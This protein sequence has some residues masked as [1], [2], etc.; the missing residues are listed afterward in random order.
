MTGASSSDRRG[1]SSRYVPRADAGEGAA[2]GR[3]NGTRGRTNGLVNG[4][5]RTNGLVNG[6]GKPNGLVNGI[7]YTNGV[8][9]RRS[10]YG[11][12][13]SSDYRRT[14]V[15]IA[16]SIV[17]MLL[18]SVFLG[19]QEPV[20]SPFAVD[21]DFSEWVGVP[22]YDDPVDA[23]PGYADLVAFAI[24]HEPGRLFAYGRTRAPMFPGNETSSVYVLID[25]PASAG[26]AVGGRDVDFLAEAWGWNGRIR[27]AA[28]REWV[29]D[30][31]R[32]NA[33]S[34]RARG[35]FDAASL[36]AEFELVLSD[37]L[38]DLDP[39]RG[40]RLSLATRFDDAVDVGLTVRSTPGA[41]TVDATPLTDLIGST[42][43][44]LELR[45]RAHLAAIDV[46]ALTF[47]HAGGGT[48][49]V[50]NPRF[51]I[52]AGQERI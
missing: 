20:P 25:D 4:M 47:D 41:L 8:R 10:T 46:R 44:V 11:I 40:L 42:S 36:G 1:L 28:L 23:V 33:T 27:E 30:P 43:M 52:A 17:V 51:T 19:T 21:G 34:L 32:D 6:L 22:T 15:F 2:Q 26:Y 38:I 39:S 14:A 48:L 49:V 13:G 50:P 35:S 24:V 12:V 29:G 16:T 3:T 5:G 45:F 9:L 37:S 7:G 18:V 31:D